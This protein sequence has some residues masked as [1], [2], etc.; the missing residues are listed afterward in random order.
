MMG[1]MWDFFRP[2]ATHSLLQFGQI[3]KRALGTKKRPGYPGVFFE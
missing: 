2:L 1:A 3:S